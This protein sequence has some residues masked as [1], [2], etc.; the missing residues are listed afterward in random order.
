ML[1]QQSGLQRSPGTDGKA[2][3]ADQKIRAA[4]VEKAQQ[5]RQEQEMTAIKACDLSIAHS[6]ETPKASSKTD[7]LT[8]TIIG[9]LLQQA[10]S[11]EA[12][13]KPLTETQ[14]PQMLADKLHTHLADF[15]QAS[16]EDCLSTFG[17]DKKSECQCFTDKLDYEA[18]FSLVI[19]TLEGEPQAQKKARQARQQAIMTTGKACGLSASIAKAKKQK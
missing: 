15:K 17:S 8:K 7:L 12:S 11:A 1:Y 13:G 4:E 18:Q 5:L 3:N 16:K 6:Q 14:I 10:K 2:L 19:K 9:E